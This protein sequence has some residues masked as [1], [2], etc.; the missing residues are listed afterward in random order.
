MYGLMT[1]SLWTRG[2]ILNPG[3][4]TRPVDE[5]MMPFPTPAMHH[6]SS[7]TPL[8]NSAART[9]LGGSQNT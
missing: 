8:S 2:T 3:V 5:A 1:P 7:A 4:R 9:G 6:P